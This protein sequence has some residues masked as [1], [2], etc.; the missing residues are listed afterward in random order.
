MRLVNLLSGNYS[1]DLAIFL[2]AVAG[3][4]KIKRP[5]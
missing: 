1:S 4:T 2:I 3:G 5:E